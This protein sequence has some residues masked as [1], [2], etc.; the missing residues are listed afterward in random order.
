MQYMAMIA[1]R[2]DIRTQRIYQLSEQNLES[3]N[4]QHCT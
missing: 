4:V 2:S 1:V 3:L